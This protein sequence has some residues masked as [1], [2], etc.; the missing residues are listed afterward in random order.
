MVKINKDITFGEVRGLERLWNEYKEL[1][2]QVKKTWK[3]YSLAN[4][5]IVECIKQYKEL[6]EKHE[7]LDSSG[8]EK[9]IKEYESMNIR[10]MLTQVVQQAKYV[11]TELDENTFTRTYNLNIYCE[12][13]PK[14]VYI[15]VE[16]KLRYKK[17]E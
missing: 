7:G 9:F 15:A 13:I 16:N 3:E 6:Y 4:E 5:K 17:G 12:E 10:N 14:E 8:L 2:E 11:K 1:A